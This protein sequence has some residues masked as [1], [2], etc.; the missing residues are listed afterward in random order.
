MPG[1]HSP[2]LG[3]SFKRSD[4]GSSI[5]WSCSTRRFILNICKTAR[6]QSQSRG[7]TKPF[8]AWMSFSMFKGLV[9]TLSKP[10][11]RNSSMSS[12][13]AFPVTPNILPRKPRALIL[14]VASMPSMTGEGEGEESKSQHHCSHLACCSP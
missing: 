5:A 8:I 13:R 4:T 9:R 10:L 1:Q 11:E 2:G 3:A 14:L 6:S 7:T 12:P